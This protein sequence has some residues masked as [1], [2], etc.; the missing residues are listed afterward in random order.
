MQK[1][2]GARGFVLVSLAVLSLVA[3]GTPAM[4]SSTCASNHVC[5]WEDNNYGGD[6]W[7]DYTS[8]GNSIQNYQ[9]DNWD[10]DNEISSVKN[11]TSL[12]LYIY[13]NDYAN[14]F[15]VWICIPPGGYSANL[16]QTHGFDND[17]EYFQL[18]GDLS[19]GG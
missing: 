4:A 11:N 7:V 18:R 3:W 17:A 14:I 9:I 16:A 1:M 5:M 12:P 6:K 8:N 2:S 19:C 10:G 15:G 13:P